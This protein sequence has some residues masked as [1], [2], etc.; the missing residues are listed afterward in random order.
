ML[1][2]LQCSQHHKLEDRSQG[3]Q[4]A[5]KYCA[6][7]ELSGADADSRSESTVKNLIDKACTVPGCTVV[8]YILL[9]CLQAQQHAQSPCCMATGAYRRLLFCVCRWCLVGS[10]CSG[11]DLAELIGKL[12]ALHCMLP[13][14][15]ST[16]TITYQVLRMACC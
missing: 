7:Q 8:S 4:S 12:P 9:Q 5:T 10:W 14:C 1:P 11:K 6:A 3:Q 16:L 2:C 15:Y 13:V